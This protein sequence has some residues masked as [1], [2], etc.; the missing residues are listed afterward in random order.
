M[1]R[2]FVFVGLAAGLTGLVLWLSARN[3]SA[4]DSRDA[5]IDLTRYG[6]LLVLAASGALLGGR[7]LNLGKAARDAAIWA[8]I[9]AGLVALYGFRAE[10]ALVG[11]RILAELDPHAPRAGEAGT[12]EVRRGMDGHFHVDI[13]INGQPV[14]F[15]VDTGA[16][17]IVLSPGDARRLGFDTAA[18]SFNRRYETANGAGWG[19][20][21]TLDAVKLGDFRLGPLAATVNGAAMDQSLL[22][23]SFL[24]LL[25]GYDFSGDTLVL[26]P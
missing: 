6:A 8:A 20:T 12:M 13:E 7:A 14:R 4:L 24:D 23:M 25:S 10:F 17:D 16:S 22:G 5:A 19:A 15:L 21:V 1:I 26:R 2:I 11:D 9:V 18:L 3:G